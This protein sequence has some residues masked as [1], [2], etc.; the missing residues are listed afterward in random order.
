MTIETDDTAPVAYEPPVAGT[1]ID[2]LL[3]SLE[4]QRRTLAW[5]CADLDATALAATLP[6]SSVTL[7]GLLKHLALVEDEYF[8]A[9]LLG[10]ELP[11]P[12]AG[13]DWDAEPDW[14][15]RSAAEDTPEELY[16][17]WRASVARSR[18]HIRRA[19][20]EGG[21]G[22]LVAYTSRRGE[23]PSLRRFLVDMI[24][25]YARHVGQADL[26]RESLDGRVSEDPPAG[27]RAW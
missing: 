18:A 5:K 11:A 19:V 1:E 22:C 4:R 2:T 12:W 9:R 7:G 25:E 10:E 14:E 23:R 15:W 27:Y 13:V 8:T 26:I 24:E 16:A 21:A 3:G 20:A 6:P 17:L